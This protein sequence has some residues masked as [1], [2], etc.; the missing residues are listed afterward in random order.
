LKRQLGQVPRFERLQPPIESIV[1]NALSYRVFR[2]QAVRWILRRIRFAVWLGLHPLRGG[3]SMKRIRKDLAL[4][5]S[6][7]TALASSAA[8]QDRHAVD[9]TLL[10]ATV[11]QHVASQD[12]DRAAIREALARPEVREMA[13]RVGLDV[14]RAAASINTLSGTD[15]ERAAGVARDVNQTLVGGASS[16]T[17]STTTII[18]I[19]LALIL[20]IVAVK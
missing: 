17:L 5:L 15:L 14:D 9:P 20:I 1:E 12:A 11:Q 6:L 13:S 7:V 3:E 10:T 8:A 18:I 16:V 19:L 4:T 2:S